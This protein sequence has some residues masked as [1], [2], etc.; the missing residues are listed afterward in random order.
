MR[1][2]KHRMMRIETGVH[3]VTLYMKVDRLNN[4]DQNRT[5]GGG[6][7]HAQELQIHIRDVVESSLSWCGFWCRRQN[8]PCLIVTEKKLRARCFLC[9]GSIQLVQITLV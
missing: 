9:I 7:D 8:E 6:W 1:T 5:R 4:R 2:A 3:C